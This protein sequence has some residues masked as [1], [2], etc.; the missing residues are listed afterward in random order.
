MYVYVCIKFSR[1]KVGYKS[2]RIKFGP[3]FSRCGCER[4]SFISC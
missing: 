3:Y 2:G 4:V 1:S